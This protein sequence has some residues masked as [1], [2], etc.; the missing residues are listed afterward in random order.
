MSEVLG[1][2]TVQVELSRL[3]LLVREP[4]RLHAVEDH[5]FGKNQEADL[6]ERIPRE[7]GERAD[8]ELPV[9]IQPVVQGCTHREEGRPVRI[10]EV[11][12]IMHN[13]GTMVS[14]TGTVGNKRSGLSVQIRVNR[15]CRERPCPRGLR[16]E[17]DLPGLMAVVEAVDGSLFAL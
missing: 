10:G 12:L 3:R 1:V 13:D 4:R 2:E 11:A 5:P 15:N 16:H 17:A 8:L 9:A 6:V 14:Q 7:R